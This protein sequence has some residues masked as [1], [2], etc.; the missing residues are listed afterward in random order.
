VRRL[1]S[2]LLLLGAGSCASRPT[3]E[4]SAVSRAGVFASGVETSR[5]REDVE[6]LVKA[7]QEDMPL[8][9]ELFDTSEIDT[10][11]RPVCH[12]TREKARQRVRERF[13]QLGY[14]VTTQDTGDER[15]PTSNVIAERR[16]TEHPEEVV[17][18]GAHFDAYYSGADDNSSGVAAVLELARLAK[19]GHF[20]RTVRFVGFDLEELGLVGST[21]YV[22]ELPGEELVASIVFDCIGYR[23]AA[24]GA[25]QGLPGFPVPTT[26]DFLAAIANEQSRPRLAELYAVASQLGYGPVRGVVVPNDG[27]GPASGSLMRSDHAPFWMAGQSAL[28]LTDTANFRNPNYHHD[29]DVP[30]TLDPDFL[31]DVTRVSAAALS[32]WAEGPQ[33]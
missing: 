26:G 25:Q 28:F 5:L 27:S 4:P 1:L 33:P 24:E 21:R 3:V 22:R 6:L 14:T 7:H 8:P 15:F 29:T 10:D 30:S 12:V 20:A 19:D 16:G 13:E 32:F 9:C 2:A 11:R 18:V 31:A 23:D 17:M